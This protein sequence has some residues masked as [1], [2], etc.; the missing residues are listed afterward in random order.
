MNFFQ[1][2]IDL[3]NLGEK[4]VQTAGIN[5]LEDLDVEAE[6]I[7][8]VENALMLLS[9]LK[10]VADEEFSKDF[11]FFFVPPQA[12]FTRLHKDWPEWEQWLAWN[13]RNPLPGISKYL[14]CKGQIYTTTGDTVSEH[15]IHG[16]TWGPDKLYNHLVHTVT[17]TGKEYQFLSYRGSY[18]EWYYGTRPDGS[19]GVALRKAYATGY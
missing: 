17:D 18:V 14:G 4:T 19:F 5:F 16:L 11:S 7:I 3:F 10:G 9:K 8:S 13:V 6:I 12:N 15:A 1:K 2:I